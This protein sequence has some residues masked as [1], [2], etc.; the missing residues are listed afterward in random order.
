MIDLGQVGQITKTFKSS[1][2]AVPSL[3]AGG[4]FG[5]ISIVGSLLAQEPLNLVLAGIGIV[6][7]ALPALQIAYFTFTNPD[8]L[9]NEEHVENKLLIAQGKMVRGDG[10]TMVDVDISSAPVEN[11]ALE[12]SSNV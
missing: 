5:P 9:Q 12:D 11:P 7:L 1:S 2:A 4:M 8:R 6:A 3:I 10:R